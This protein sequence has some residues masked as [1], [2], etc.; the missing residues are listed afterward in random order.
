MP[1]KKNA[2]QVCLTTC[3][4]VGANC[5]QPTMFSDPAATQIGSSYMENDQVKQSLQL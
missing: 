2:T 3:T 4:F 1:L 5:G